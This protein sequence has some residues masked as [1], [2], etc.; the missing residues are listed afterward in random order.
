MRSNADNGRENIHSAWESK[1]VAMNELPPSVLLIV[2]FVF[3]SV[4][5]EVVFK[6]TKQNCCQK[7]SEKE[8]R[9]ARVDDGE[10]VNLE[11]LRK[12]RMARVF[13]HSTLKMNVC[14]NPFCRIREFHFHG[15][16][17]RNVFSFQR[18]GNNNN[19]DDLVAVIG[20]GELQMSK[21]EVDAGLFSVL[22][23]FIHLTNETPHRE[24]V[25]IHLK[26]II[27]LDGI[28]KFTDVIVAESLFAQRLVFKVL[29]EIQLISSFYH[30]ISFKYLP[31]VLVFE[32]QM[33]RW[34][35]WE[36]VVLIR[37]GRI[38]VGTHFVR[39]KRDTLPIFIHMII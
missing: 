3:P 14:C 22:N 38:R 25:V 15:F 34:A 17:F 33:L 28:L 23:S 20:Y 7:S 5:D 26:V 13:V 24:V 1:H 29:P 37:F 35:E 21:Q 11:M 31:D 18:V 27:L 39:I 9:D 19:F 30:P 8:N 12:K 4:F 6:H 16:F 36:G 2:F 10:P 32:F